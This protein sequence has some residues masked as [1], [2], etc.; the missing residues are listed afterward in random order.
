MTKEE[1][2]T[3]RDILTDFRAGKVELDYVEAHVA[4]LVAEARE[5]GYH[6]D[7]RPSALEA[8]FND[9][10]APIVNEALRRIG[11]YNQPALHDGDAVT[12]KG[13]EGLP[14]GVYRLG[15][16]RSGL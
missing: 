7:P 14:D 12:V 13:V 1:L 5:A 9:D 8:A 3:L 6:C 15:K 10:K 11:S 2:L 4:V 16:P